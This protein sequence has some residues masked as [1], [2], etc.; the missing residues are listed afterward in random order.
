MWNDR[1][2]E[3]NTDEGFLTWYEVSAPK[4]NANALGQILVDEIFEVPYRPGRREFRFDVVVNNALK[5]KSVSSFDLMSS[6]L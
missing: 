4:I 6:G 2:F 3:Y 5:M 1:R